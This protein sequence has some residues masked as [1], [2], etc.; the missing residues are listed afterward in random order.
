MPNDDSYDDIT[1]VIEIQVDNAE[2]IRNI[3]SNLKKEPAARRTKGFLRAKLREIQCKY[4]DFKELHSQ[5]CKSISRSDRKNIPYFSKNT[6]D[7]IDDIQSQMEIKIEEWIDELQG[8]LPSVVVNFPAD[9]Q[10]N[11]HNRPDKIRLERI[12]IENFSG[13]LHKWMSFKGLYTTLV[14]ENN[15]IS[16]VEKFH[17]LISI[18]SGDAKRLISHYNITAENYTAA[19]KSIQDRFDN[20]RILVN[21]E[22]KTLIDQPN[23][24]QESTTRIRSMLDMSQECLNSLRNLNIDISTWDPIIIHILV[25]KLDTETHRHWENSLDNPKDLPTYQQF[26]N[27]L[28]K[29][30]Q[31]LENITTSKCNTTSSTS[32]T[33]EQSSTQYKVKQPLDRTVNHYAKQP[34]NKQRTF[35]AGSMTQCQFCG[36]QHN[37]FSCSKFI[38]LNHR[39]RLHMVEEKGL[40]LNCFG[41]HSSETC[42]SS[43]RC[44]ECKHRHHTLI[45]D[46]LLHTPSIKSSASS[47]SS[48]YHQPSSAK[49]STSSSSFRSTTPSSNL[50]TA[51]S[52][53]N[54]ESSQIINSLHAD[55]ATRFINAPALLAT[56]II[57][58]NAYNGVH[59]K[60]RC[61]IDQG[62]TASFITK[63]TAQILKLK[64]TKITAIINGVGTQSTKYMIHINIKSTYKP[65]ELAVEA[66][67]MPKI[68][69]N[70]PCNVLTPSPNWNHI[71]G[72]QLADPQYYR[73]GKIDM[74]LG[75]DVYCNILLYGVR[76]GHPGEP[77]AQNTHLGWI[78][79]GP[80][81]NDSHSSIIVMHINASIEEQLKKFWELEELP[82]SPV[83]SQEDVF[84]PKLIVVTR[85]DVTSLNC[86]SNRTDICLVIQK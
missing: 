74:L 18:L 5:I 77:I 75:A 7:E 25:H 23:I 48:S 51:I 76:K 31:V 21:N 30:L 82:A 40:C 20:R 13:D 57:E 24:T 61:L 42:R 11:V 1:R 55:T 33:S 70:L 69:D 27:F 68:T 37:V 32:S 22:I 84:S 67:V 86:P 28:E 4:G 47:A 59:H 38:S 49:S 71:N 58:V 6:F 29:R 45:H 36:D 14:H 78:L 54:T 81:A 43:T 52:T 73:P 16:N 62:S 39:Q 56:A 9:A 41:T 15:D 80:V 44:K 10:I 2:K 60:L 46:A 53:N 63:Y 12:K 72:L 8:P 85:M 64:R 50:S 3:F 83:L 26:I 34:Y 35:F 19:W 79:S 66:I 65:F 17:H